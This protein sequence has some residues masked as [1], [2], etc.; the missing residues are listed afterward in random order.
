MN[1]EQLREYCLAMPGATE[2]IKWGADLVFSVGGKM[3]CVTS[4]DGG[5]D[6]VASMT[7]KVRDD[8]FEELCETEFFEPAAYV[9]RY[10]WVAF[11]SPEM[12]AKFSDKK[13]KAYIKQSYEIV[14]DKLPK[15]K[16]DEIGK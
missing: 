1:I 14:R 4:A 5:G 2:D 12:R 15:K 16:R 9:G 10:K 7:F 13:L 8:E 6:G 3:F 11:R